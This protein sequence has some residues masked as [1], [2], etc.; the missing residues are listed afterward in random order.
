MEPVG[1][2]VCRET[3]QVSYKISHWFNLSAGLGNSLVCISEGTAE[4]EGGHGGWDWKQG[5]VPP[6]QV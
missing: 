2:R 6:S 5:S 4:P 3:K 1:V